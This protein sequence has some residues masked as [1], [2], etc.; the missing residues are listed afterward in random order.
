MKRFDWVSGAT[1]VARA[2][3]SAHPARRRACAFA[4]AVRVRVTCPP[5]GARN[6]LILRAHAGLCA[7]LRSS[8]ASRRAHRARALR[9][10]AFVVGVS[11]CVAA[12]LWIVV[13]SLLLG[14]ADE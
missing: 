3:P 8:R 14:H 2:A 11:L 10:E 13:F 6:P 4:Q 1:W 7:R 12:L 9:L 5:L